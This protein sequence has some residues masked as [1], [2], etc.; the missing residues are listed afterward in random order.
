MAAAA[1][2]VSLS[3]V[4]PTFNER[5]NAERLLT[6]LSAVRDRLPKDLEILI[7]DDQSPDGTAEAVRSTGAGA[8]LPVRVVVR[9]G[10]RSLG[11]AIVEGLEESR[12]ELICVMDADLSHPPADLPRLY[13][14]LDGADGV[15]AS[16]YAEGGQVHGWPWYRR[17]VSFGATSLATAIVRNPCSDPVSGFFLFRRSA[18]ADIPLTG[19]GN[20]PLV[21]ILAAKLLTI[22][23]VPYEFRDRE[24]G[25]SKLN[26]VG[27]SEFAQ[28]IAIL[29]LRLVRSG[30]PG[31]SPQPAEPVESRDP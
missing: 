24:H 31:L 22:H 23:E 16:R 19:I 29:A 6:G 11:K 14:A 28:L 4:I 8:D 3:I 7:I 9:P 10:P 15:V 25:R 1:E 13:D 5:E 30:S 26:P 21:E 27:I 2:F 12:G 18:L 17:L 20:K